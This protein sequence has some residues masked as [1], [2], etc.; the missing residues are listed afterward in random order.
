MPRKLQGAGGSTQ[1]PP[2][3][4]KKNAD[5]SFHHWAKQLKEIVEKA[6]RVLCLEL[7]SWVNGMDAC[8]HCFVLLKRYLSG[9]RLF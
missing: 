8:A 5:I 9:I 7:K 3:A 4:Q 2:P 6:H 1:V